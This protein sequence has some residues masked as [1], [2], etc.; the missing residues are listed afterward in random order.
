ML[1]FRD[2]IFAN[3]E[4]L[5]SYIVRQASGGLKRGAPRPRLCFHNTVRVGFASLSPPYAVTTGLDP[6]VHDAPPMP[7]RLPDQV[8]Q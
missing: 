4:G 8:R 2:N 1:S 6:V 5:I 3:P 7:H